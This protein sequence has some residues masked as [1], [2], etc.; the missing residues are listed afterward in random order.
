MKKNVLAVLCTIFVMVLSFNVLRP[1]AND[2][3]RE[4]RMA[5]EG[6][7]ATRAPDGLRYTLKRNGKIVLEMKGKRKPRLLRGNTEC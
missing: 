3:F 6:F 5:E 4:K 2:Y 1:M 7:T